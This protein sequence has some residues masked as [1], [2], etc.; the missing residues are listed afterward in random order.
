MTH[1]ILDTC[2]LS[3]DANKT[4]PIR[5]RGEVEQYDHYTT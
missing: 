4:N 5:F 2:Q 3:H 1:T